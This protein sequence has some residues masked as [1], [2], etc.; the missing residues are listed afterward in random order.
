M[1]QSNYIGKKKDKLD[2][3]RKSLWSTNNYKVENENIIQSAGE[4]MFKLE[5]VPKPVLRHEIL[6]VDI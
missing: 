3:E 1:I 5:G 6:L 2:K 4:A